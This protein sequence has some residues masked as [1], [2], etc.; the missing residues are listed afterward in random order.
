M[1]GRAL[2]LATV[3]VVAGTLGCN[4]AIGGSSG[5][6][7]TPGS[8]NQP[9]PPPP[10]PPGGALT[11]A[12]ATFASAANIN[13]R[14]ATQGDT[15]TLTF[16]AEVVVKAADPNLEFVLPVK[17]N[18]FGTG[19]TLKAGNA[20]NQV[21]ITLGANPNLR[22]SGTFAVAAVGSGDSTGIDVPTVATG[23]VLGLTGTKPSPG[24]VDLAGPLME[25]W[26]AV[27]TMQL[28]RG[29]HT[30]TLL[31]DGRILITGGL[32]DGGGGVGLV[33]A[34]NSEV[35]D[36]VGNA[37]TLT[38]TLGG[39]VNGD[40]MVTNA[41]FGV[42]AA[43]PAGTAFGPLP[44]ARTDHTATKLPDGRVLVAG[45]YGFE[46]LDPAQANPTPVQ[47]DLHTA[48]LFDPKTNT[49]AQTAGNLITPRSHHSAAVLANGKVLV[50]G[51]I[52][53]GQNVTPN[54]A[55]VALASAEEFD[56]ATGMFTA[57]NAN[58]M[59]TP[60]FDGVLEVDA[61]K[62]QVLY[63]GGVAL[64]PNVNPPQLALS[65]GADLFDEPTSTFL[66]P[67]SKPTQDLRWQGAAQDGTGTTYIFGGNGVAVVS[68]LVE[69][70]TG[71][72]FTSL[73]SLV[74]ARARAKGDTMG[75]NIVVVAGGTNLS[76][77]PGHELAS[78]EVINTDS[79]KVETAPSMAHARNSFTLTAAN[80]RVYA[81]GGLNG[82]NG[83]L[84]DSTGGLPIGP[85]E[86]Y[87]RP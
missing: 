83:M 75:G 6:S 68:S 85:A 49:F 84:G 35:Y 31:N 1:Q 34:L 41:V 46:N 53:N 15:V 33:Y 50:T 74:T 32:V 72:K 63:S 22:V 51:G 79:Q 60:R 36:P 12:T 55:P 70:Y 56:P 2:V 17:G 18:T 71:G 37:F 5:K 14:S 43:N 80:G 45:G 4:G 27:A 40:M 42:S 38:S 25:Q 62:N 87:E 66:S 10:P 77:K 8:T 64:I 73:P 26:Q 29:V 9:P 20:T 69:S 65:G 48:H 82:D 44:V 11:L 21:L 81:I 67:A 30:A 52:N 16:S 47:Q 61:A 58:G 7:A 78:V 57:A 39:Q 59:T 23:N 86:V 13:S 54:V 28:P 24:P 3:V 76:G 19:A